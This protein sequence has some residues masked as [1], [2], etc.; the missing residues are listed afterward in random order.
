MATLEPSA[1]YVFAYAAIVFVPRLLT[2][3]VAQDIDPLSLLFVVVLVVAVVIV[4]VAF[5]VVAVCCC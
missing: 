5:V 2:S 3:A 4:V 1:F